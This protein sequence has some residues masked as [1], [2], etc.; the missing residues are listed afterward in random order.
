VCTSL[1]VSAQLGAWHA[2]RAGLQVVPT[3]PTRSS[4]SLLDFSFFTLVPNDGLM[5]VPC[6]TTPTQNQQHVRALKTGDGSRVLD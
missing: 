4:P 5:A 6:S 1:T 2:S 3:W